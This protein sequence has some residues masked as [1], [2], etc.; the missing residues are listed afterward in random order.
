MALIKNEYVDQ[1]NRTED[2]EINPHSYC[3]I[4]FN[5]GI[6]KISIGGGQ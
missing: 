1:W 3:H 5:G 4:I 6:K 2:L